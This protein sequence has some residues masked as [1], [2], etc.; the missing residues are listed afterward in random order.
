MHRARKAAFTLI[1]LLVVIAVIVIPAGFLFSF[2]R[3]MLFVSAAVSLYDL[4]WTALQKATCEP[5]NNEEDRSPPA[6]G[7]CPSFA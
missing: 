2:R 3:P 4:P 1:E 7:G 6:R 5:G